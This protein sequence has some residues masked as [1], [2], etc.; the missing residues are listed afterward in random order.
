MEVFKVLN[1]KTNSNTVIFTV[2]EAIDIFNLHRDGK[3]ALSIAMSKSYDVNRVKTLLLR[4]AEIRDMMERIVKRQAVLNRIPAVPATY[5]EETGEELTPAVPEQIEYVPVPQTFE[6]LVERSLE[7]I[8][9]DHPVSEDPIFEANSVEEI[10]NGVGYIVSE[11][12]RVSKLE[13]DGTFD[14]WKEQV[15]LTEEG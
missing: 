3:G 15:T 11:I 6:K 4:F 5:D 8:N 1:P 14:W 12:I 9:K 10:I 2:T 13:K 7:L